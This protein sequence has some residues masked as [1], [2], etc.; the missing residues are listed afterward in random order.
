MKF[1]THYSYLK[2]DFGESLDSSLVNCTIPY[3][4]HQ[5]HTSAD[6]FSA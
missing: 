5:R 1:Y 4:R 2:K 6:G 3:S